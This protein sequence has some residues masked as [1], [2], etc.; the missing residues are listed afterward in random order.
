MC[1][2]GQGSEKR[3]KKI[4]QMSVEEA[5]L[6]VCILNHTDKPLLELTDTLY[7][8]HHQGNGR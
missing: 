7:Q 2:Q 3:K 4:F 1:F 6:A 5:K 8:T